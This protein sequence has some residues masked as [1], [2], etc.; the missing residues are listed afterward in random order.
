MHIS[1]SINLGIN[2]WLSSDL[3]INISFSG[4][5]LMDIRLSSDLSINIFLSSNI[6]MDIS[7]SG[8][9]SMDIRF[10]SRVQVGIGYRWVIDSSIQ[11][12]ISNRSMGKIR[13]NSLN[14]S[15]TTK[16]IIDTVGS[17]SVAIDIRVGIGTSSISSWED[18]SL[19]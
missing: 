18:G 12:T 17:S 7:L 5:L 8:N 1:F 2:I 15:D 6:L 16:T 10:S 19:S 11:T 9:I 13:S 14:G 3:G 4:N